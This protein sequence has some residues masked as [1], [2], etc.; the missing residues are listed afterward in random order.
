MTFCWCL[1]CSD[2][3]IS[4][5]DCVEHAIFS[6]LFHCFYLQLWKCNGDLKLSLLFYGI[7]NIVIF[8][9]KLL[10]GKYFLKPAVF[11][12]HIDTMKLVYFGDL[13]ILYSFK[14]Q[15]VAFSKFKN[16]SYIR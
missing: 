11:R 15:G 14:K 8:T 13:C 10:C 1:Y 12:L 16:I 7:N 4:I 9:W 5:F 6:T 2:I 3:F